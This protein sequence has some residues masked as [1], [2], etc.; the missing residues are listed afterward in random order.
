MEIGTFAPSQLIAAR[1]GATIERPEEGGLSVAPR[2]IL[3]TTSGQLGEGVNYARDRMAQAFQATAFV[4]A[5]SGGEAKSGPERPGRSKPG[6]GPASGPVSEGKPG[7][8]EPSTSKPYS[9]SDDL[10]KEMLEN[11]DKMLPYRMAEHQR[12][13]QEQ[14]YLARLQEDL[15]RL[16]R[17]RKQLAPSTP[18]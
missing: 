8:D 17:E 1:P 5:D 18:R 15:D 4:G 16:E 9:S 2:E 13:V 6:P 14:L 7:P 3:D 11:H 12:R 10:I